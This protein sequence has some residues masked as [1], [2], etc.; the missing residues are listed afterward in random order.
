MI[1]FFEDKIKAVN[2]LGLQ[3]DVIWNYIMW[4]SLHFQYSRPGTKNGVAKFG[5]GGNTATIF[6]KSTISSPAVSNN[7]AQGIP[8]A[9]DGV[10]SVP[11]S[12]GPTLR[13]TFQQTLQPT[14]HPTNQPSF[15]PNGQSGTAYLQNIFFNTPD[16][17]GVPTSIVYIQM[18][19]CLPTSS[20]TTFVMYSISNPYSSGGLFG[21]RC[22]IF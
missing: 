15:A 2:A 16:C 11:P 20:S 9:T 19:T 18:N 10:F 14:N 3:R 5:L 7:I 8:V 6:G 1:Q 13:P 21:R 4:S 22:F 17:S 12:P